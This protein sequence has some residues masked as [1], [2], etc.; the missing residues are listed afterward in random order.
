MKFRLGLLWAIFLLL[1]VTGCGAGEEPF[2]TT[3]S[4]PPTTLPLPTETSPPDPTPSSTTQAQPT[5][6]PTAL[7]ISESEYQGWWT[8]TNP[9][10]GFSLKLP[11]D[12]VVNE[13]TTGQTARDGY[14]LQIQPQD[15]GSHLLIRM[16]FREK[17]GE[18]Y[19]W[20][21]GVGAGE[22][23]K[24]NT[25]EIAGGPAQRNYFVCPTGQVNSIWYMGLDTPHLQRENLEFGF[26]YTFFERYC[27]E[28]YSL[29]GKQQHI[30]ELII[31]SLTV[32]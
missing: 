4:I 22:F 10:S 6:I 5:A 28:G 17:G 31:A 29:G 24:G 26:I 16:T 25:L 12:W 21:T 9:S 11:A 1:L 3:T 20:P 32:P 30:G 14:T 8:Y 7:P 13:I 15:A 23:L 27:E 19:I 18:S 2:P